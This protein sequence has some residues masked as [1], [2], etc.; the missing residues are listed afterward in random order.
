MTNDT[1][2]GSAAAAAAAAAALAAAEVP[3]E[4]E[5]TDGR[6]EEGTLVL[7]FREYGRG[8]GGC[9]EDDDI[10]EARDDVVIPRLRVV[11]V[12]CDRRS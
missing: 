12:G 9:A 7:P 5:W 6:L 1:S 11:T 2:L 10:E 8:D 3:L 4:M